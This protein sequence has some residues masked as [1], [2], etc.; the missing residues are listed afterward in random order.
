MNPAEVRELARTR[1]QRREAPHP[2]DQA[3]AALCWPFELGGHRNSALG[4]SVEGL[5]QTVS[6]LTNNDLPFHPD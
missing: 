4:F 6:K 5:F 3:G 2:Y 1:V